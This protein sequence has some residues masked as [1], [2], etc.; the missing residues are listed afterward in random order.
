MITNLKEHILNLIKEEAKNS[1]WNDDDLFY[2][3]KNL[4]IDQRGRIGEYFFR[5]VFKELNMDVKYVD[6]DCGDYDLIVNDI[7]IE[8]KTATLDVNN[9]FQHEG[10]KNSNL[11]D[12]I[13]FLDISQ[14]SFYVT[15][16]SKDKFNFYENNEHIILNNKKQNIHFRGKDN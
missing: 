12:V 11:W 6:N 4:S 13:A 3:I 8:V 7:K 5:D 16:L 9:K 10:I 14:N 15:F 2:E 1:K